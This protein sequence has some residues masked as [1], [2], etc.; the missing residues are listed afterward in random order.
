MQAESVSASSKMLSLVWWLPA[1]GKTVLCRIKCSGLGSKTSLKGGRISWLKCWP[2]VIRAAAPSTCM[3]FISVLALQE[4]MSSLTSCWENNS[5]YIHVW[6][7]S[8]HLGKES[9]CRCKGSHEIYTFNKASQ[10]KTSSCWKKI[11]SCWTNAEVC[12]VP[13]TSKWILSGFIFF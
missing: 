7:I 8:I 6:T 10:L 1:P 11:C 13:H 9:F 3:V 12:S 2:M 5:F 4:L